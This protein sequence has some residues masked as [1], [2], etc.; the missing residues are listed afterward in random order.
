MKVCE[1]LKEAQN[2]SF[3]HEVI[4]GYGNH[5]NKTDPLQSDI[6]SPN[7]AIVSDAFFPFSVR[8]VSKNIHQLN[9]LFER[10]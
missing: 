9:P 3:G 2:L 6:P 4:K 8:P 10:S 5:L 7:S 1:P